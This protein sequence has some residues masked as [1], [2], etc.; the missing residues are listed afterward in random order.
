MKNARRINSFVSL[1]LLCALFI[2]IQSVFAVQYFQ[3]NLVKADLSKNTIGGIKLILY[4]IK[5]YNDKIVVNK[6]SD[7]EYVILLPETSNS[8]TIKPAL[9]L[10]ADLVKN[11][12]VKTQ[13]YDNNLKGYTKITILTF[14]PVEIVPETKILQ[15][16]ISESDYKELLAQKYKQTPTANNQSKTMI[17]KKE[18]AQLAQKPTQ[19][20]Q[21]TKQVKKTV[22][23]ITPVLASKTI[24]KTQ[25]SYKTFRTQ[26]VVTKT[27]LK[28]AN[29]E[30]KTRAKVYKKTSVYKKPI[31]VIKKE[32]A[33]RPIVNKP[34]V[35]PVHVEK[36][37]VTPK[38]KAI[39]KPVHIEKP[40]VPV[41][42][43]VKTA[44]DEEQ[45]PS[46]INPPVEEK[47][48]VS[49]T[50]ETVKTITKPQEPIAVAPKVE[51]KTAKFQSPVI[52]QLMA[53]VKKIKG[54][55]KYKNI[56]KNNLY[57]ILGIL[58]ASFI[59]LL[60]I[61]RIKSRNFKKQKEIFKSHLQEQPVQPKDYTEDITEDMD[62]KEKFQTYVDAKQVQE[63][64]TEI[65]PESAIVEN[66]ELDE[67]FMNESFPETIESEAP[68]EEVI[69]ADFDEEISIPSVDETQVETEQESIYKEDF[70]EESELPQDYISQ[71]EETSDEE[72]DRI[73]AQEEETELSETQTFAEDFSYIESLSE[74]YQPQQ[75]QD[76]FIK[77][78]F[79]IDA[80]KGFYLVDFEDKTALVGHIDEEYFVLKQF[81]RKVEGRLQARMDEHKGDSVNY[82]TK[83]GDFKA[84]VKVT[85]QNMNLLIEL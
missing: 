23:T 1:I 85:P 35:K 81:D 7:F 76:E 14:K 12:E 9:S 32:T 66:Q 5:P 27:S 41:R 49:S 62:W 73:F 63:S 65:K 79:P 48:V 71:A 53:P 83:V 10:V 46:I 8:L 4:T 50:Q 2:T 52:Q 20:V 44:P 69:H 42:P 39:T 18:P 68:Q 84:L 19:M 22:K 61:V 59:L 29:N 36:A 55:Q 21:K 30:Y 16:S 67:L 64:D 26:N 56:I 37:M 80:T 17:S 33:S 13:Q 31:T 28:T 70:V 38:P 57:T 45:Q 75:E 11:I 82:M 24:T 43:R 60:L 25:G 6:K 72:L 74:E 58:V 78:E 51:T 15:P 3:N 47:P 34:I 77:S 54:F 40:V